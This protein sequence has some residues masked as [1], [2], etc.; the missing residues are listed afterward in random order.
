MN[1]MS[2]H[3]DYNLDYLRIINFPRWVKSTYSMKLS[4]KIYDYCDTIESI[5]FKLF[6]I[7]FVIKLIF[8]NSKYDNIELEGIKKENNKKYDIFANII[9][10]DYKTISSYSLDKPL[11]SVSTTINQS[12]AD[13]TDTATSSISS[14]IISKFKN[15]L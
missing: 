4:D 10:K 1:E 2:N 5:G 14:E 13:M 12:W 8:S 7:D 3:I 6:S 9:P 11:L 15:M